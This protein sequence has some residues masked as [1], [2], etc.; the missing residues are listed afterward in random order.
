[1]TPRQHRFVSEY[2]VDRNGAA[3]AVRAGYSVRSAKQIAYQPL[4][5]P[6]VAEGVQ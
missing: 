1:M 6:D 3:A 2:L 5:K 4:A